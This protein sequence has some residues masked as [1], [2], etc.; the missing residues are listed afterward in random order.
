M[1]FLFR[2]V[3]FLV[4]GLLAVLLW[5]YMFVDRCLDEGG[6]WNYAAFECEK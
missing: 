2:I 4:V 3:I 1:K 6:R 5:D